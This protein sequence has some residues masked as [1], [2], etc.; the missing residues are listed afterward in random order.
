MTAVLPLGSARALVRNG[1][2]A[3]DLRRLAAMLLG[4]KGCAPR[5]T[6]AVVQSLDNEINDRELPNERQTL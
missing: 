1:S 6:R 3:Q 4:G 2:P 5:I